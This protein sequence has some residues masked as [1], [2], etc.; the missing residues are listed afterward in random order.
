MPHVPTLP[1]PARRWPASFNRQPKAHAPR[2]TVG[3]R[4]RHEHFDSHRAYAC[5]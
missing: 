5:G 1:P 2:S 3:G 4:T